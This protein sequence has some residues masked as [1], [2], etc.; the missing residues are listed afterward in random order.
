MSNS[1]RP[2]TDGI[3]AWV[4]RFRNTRSVAVPEFRVIRS[5]RVEDIDRFAGRYMASDTHRDLAS[6]VANKPSFYNVKT[7]LSLIEG[8]P[9]KPEQ[10]WLSWF[11]NS[12]PLETN[13]AGPIDRNLQ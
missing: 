5:L 1:A 4:P 9:S 12:P 7:V 2:G 11:L 8:K 3:E 6:N 10:S 13:W